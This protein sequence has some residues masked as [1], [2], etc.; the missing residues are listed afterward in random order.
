MGR[1]IVHPLD[2][3]QTEPWNENLLDYLAIHLQDN[4]YDLKSALTLIA[5][6]QAYQSE[7]ETLTQDADVS[8][9]IFA[10][11]RT[12]RMTAEQFVDSLWQLTDSAPKSFDAPCFARQ[13]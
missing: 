4:A 10:G 5:S 8:G 1:G 7:V 12:K 6:S 13:S 9:Y 3:M 11:P 2:A